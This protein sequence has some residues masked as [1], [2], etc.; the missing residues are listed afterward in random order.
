MH[1]YG[2]H[3]TAFASDPQLTPRSEAPAELLT[4]PNQLEIPRCW[5]PG[6]ANVALHMQWAL[7]QGAWYL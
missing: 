2:S 5:P 4:A 3:G 1:R 7:I 6:I